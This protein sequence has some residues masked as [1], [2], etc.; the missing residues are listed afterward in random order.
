MAVISSNASGQH[1]GWVHA[2]NVVF[3]FVAAYDVI[4]LVTWVVLLRRDRAEAV[5]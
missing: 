4:A 5:E 2:K 3:P 1:P